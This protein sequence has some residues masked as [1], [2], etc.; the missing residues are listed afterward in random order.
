MCARLS[1]RNVGSKEQELR[2]LLEV[3][4]IKA[5]THVLVG[6]SVS[7]SRGS[8]A[9]VWDHIATLLEAEDGTTVLTEEYLREANEFIRLK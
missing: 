6:G 7:C 4:R 3:L 5:E 8:C 2:Q 1:D 9:Q